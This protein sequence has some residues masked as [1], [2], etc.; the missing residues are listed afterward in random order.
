MKRQQKE[1]LSDYFRVAA[2]YDLLLEIIDE[3]KHKG[4]DTFP[5]EQKAREVNKE[6]LNIQDLNPWLVNVIQLI[7]KENNS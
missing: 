6:I 5:Y 3:Q 1:I 2:Q 7:Y 4:L